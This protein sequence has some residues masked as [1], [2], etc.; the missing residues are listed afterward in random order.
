MPGSAAAMTVRT[1]IAIRHWRRSC[2]AV[3]NADPHRG[4]DR[5]RELE[6]EPHRGERQR[7]ELVVVARLDQHVELVGVEVLQEVDGG[8]QH[9]EV[10][11]RDTDEEQHR[12]HRHQRHDHMALARVERGQHE[13]VD[14][15]EDQR[16]RE[17]QREIERD[18]QRRRERLA[19]P[20]RDRFGVGRAV[21]RLGERDRQL[22]GLA[23]KRRPRRRRQT[24]VGRRQRAQRRE[25]VRPSR[26]EN[27]C[28]TKICPS[29][30][31]PA[32]VRD[33]VDLVSGLLTMFSSS[34]FCQKQT[35]KITTTATTDTISRVRSSSRCSTSVSRSSCPMGLTAVAITARAARYRAR[36]GANDGPPKPDF[37]SAG[38][39][40]GQGYSQGLLDTQSAFFIAYQ[41]PY[42][43]RR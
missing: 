27:C 32:R 25:L 9:E 38:S 5:D 37:W 12:H 1:M 29:T 21:G 28:A 39:P 4:Q 18:G 10:A 42:A 35:P 43:G 34:L 31:L 7:R 2:W 3:R 15:V 8:R 16:Q 22:A 19:G 20:E 40:T 30:P 6:H 26:S 33:S 23:G 11:E 13:R 14:L 36:S 41:V 24:R 17:Q